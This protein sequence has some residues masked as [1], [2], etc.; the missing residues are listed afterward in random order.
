MA[1]MSI[2]DPR[3]Q[4]MG[5]NKAI[6]IAPYGRLGQN[7]YNQLSGNHQML[8][9]SPDLAMTRK[10]YE[11]NNAKYDETWKMGHQRRWSDSNAHLS[12]V[13][14]DYLM[15]MGAL[16]QQQ[17]SS[18]PRICKCQQCQ[19]NY[20]CQK[21]EDY[22]MK[23]PTRPKVSFGPSQMY[24]IDVELM[25]QQQQQKEKNEKKQGMNLELLPL[26]AQMSF[27][28]MPEAGFMCSIN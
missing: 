28:M 26:D 23:A 22:I 21:S 10:L 2:Y 6:E 4:S 19:E 12:L 24:P 8:T 16:E 7:V 17:Q 9:Y 13:D 15:E 11:K 20:Y 5:N 3:I 1:S 25:Q 14:R 18:H 27:Q